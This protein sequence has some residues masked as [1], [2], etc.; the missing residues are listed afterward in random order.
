MKGI[1]NVYKRVKFAIILLLASCILTIVGYGHR[2][3]TNNNSQSAKDFIDKSKET[4][5]SEVVRITSE[6]TIFNFP[7]K[8]TTETTTFNI[9]LSDVRTFRDA[10]VACSS[11]NPTS[12]TI[13]FVVI[14]N[15][16]PFFNETDLTTFCYEIYPE[17]DKLGRVG[18]CEGCLSYETMPSI[19]EERGDISKVFPSGF[20][21]VQYD[22]IDEY[23]WLYN[24]C[25][26]IAWCLSEENSNERNLITGTRYMNVEG[27]LPYETQVLN[28]IL[29]T[30]NHVMYRVTP[31]FV[32]EELVCRGVIMEAYSVEDNG[33]LS[34]CVFCFNV[35][36][37]I[38]IDYST[39]LSSGPEY[40]GN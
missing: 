35:Q 29:E 23:G 9:A 12:E 38:S 8:N 36:P 21:N 27:M 20:N 40:T 26:C 34:F 2:L 4:V 22:G 15:N 25:H 10:Y 30:G 13:P 28:Y 6:E 19:D 7:I 24:R 1:I 37:G 32:N 17:L 16:A 31:V 5:V 39:G 11:L 18:S 3:V 33:K 14:N